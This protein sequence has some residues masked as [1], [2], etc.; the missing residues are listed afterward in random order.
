[1]DTFQ[2]G[3][4]L[5][6]SLR[7]FARNFFPFLLISFFF[8]IPVLLYTQSWLR[9]VENHG[10]LGDTLHF[11]AVMMALSALSGT[12]ITATLTYRVVTEV[13]GQRAGWGTCIAKG[14]S[15]LWGALGVALVGS[16]AIVGGLVLLL[17]PGIIVA[18][19]Y[20]VSVPASIVERPGVI[21][22]LRR[23]QE[24]TQGHKGQ[25]FGLLVIVAVLR[26]LLSKVVDAAI[27]V[28]TLNDA[29]HLLYLHCGVEATAASLAAVIA[30]VTYCA[31]R[32]E[33]DGA[34]RTQ[35]GTL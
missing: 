24:L 15:T 30:A 23:S 6:R 2:V 8:F 11:T 25:V 3:T 27:P 16:I 32:V 22:A 12:L 20:Y 29:R 4:V 35:L 17:V 7:V 21:G 34:G 10:V 18:C 9:D 19:M 5:G 31:L 33:K 1:M 28:E 13:H 26:T 14:V